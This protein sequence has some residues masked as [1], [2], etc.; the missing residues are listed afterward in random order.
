V[1]QIVEIKPETAKNF[2]ILLDNSVKDLYTLEGNSKNSQTRKIKNPETI[3]PKGRVSKKRIKSGIETT[4]PSKRAALTSRQQ[5]TSQTNEEE[6]ENNPQENNSGKVN[7][8]IN[9]L[10]SK[11]KEDNSIDTPPS[12]SGSKCPF[13][14]E[15]LPF[16]IPPRIRLLLNKIAKQNGK[17]R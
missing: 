10:H 3:K 12:S 13:C 1:K 15:F 16:P 11:S 5:N 14:S 4:R 9:L 17:N 8:P 2:Y 6:K 7:E